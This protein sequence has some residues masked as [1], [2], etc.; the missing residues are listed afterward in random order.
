MSSPTKEDVKRVMDEVEVLDLPDG[1]HWQMISDR[2]GIPAESVT[3]YI[4]AD[5]DFFGY[6]RVGG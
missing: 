1:A 2:L 5:P 4:F 6:K 3:D